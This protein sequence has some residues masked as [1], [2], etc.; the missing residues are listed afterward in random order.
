MTAESCR[1]LEQKPNDFPAR[2]FSAPDDAKFWTLSILSWQMSVRLM[3]P[4]KS[5]SKLRTAARAAYWGW[6]AFQLL[7]VSYCTIIMFTVDYSVDDHAAKNGAFCSESLRR[8]LQT[9]GLHLILKPLR[10]TIP[11]IIIN[12]N[13]ETTGLCWTAFRRF[14]IRF[15]QGT[16]P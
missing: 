13:N 5:A 14:S 9:E 4:S 6:K 2:I 1:T 12:C 11:F 3:V 16:S 8:F 7:R 15:V 10:T